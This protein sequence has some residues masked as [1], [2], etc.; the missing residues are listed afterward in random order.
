[1]RPKCIRSN[2]PKCITY[3]IYYYYI[4]LW[5]SLPFLN[6]IW[7]HWMCWIGFDVNGIWSQV[8]VASSDTY[9]NF[10]S[11]NLTQGFWKWLHFDICLTLHSHWLSNVSILKW[12]LWRLGR[13]SLCLIWLFDSEEYLHWHSFCSED[14]KSLMTMSV[15]VFKRLPNI[16]YLPS[17]FLWACGL[18]LRE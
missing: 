18:W 7:H 9:V 1:M 3:S 16:L 14:L 17:L 5:H 10:Y 12:V 4:T 2:K 8:S 6:K 11:L 15:C 13:T